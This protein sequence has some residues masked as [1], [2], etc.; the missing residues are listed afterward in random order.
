MV[1]AP[2]MHSFR[3]GLSWSRSPFRNQC[4]AFTPMPGARCG[5]GGSPRLP[6]PRAS[7]EGS[8]A[9]NRHL[10]F[11][12]NLRTRG[13]GKG[14]QRGDGRRRR[15]GRARRRRARSWQMNGGCRGAV[16][17]G[18]RPSG[19]RA[20]GRRPEDTHTFQGLRPPERKRARGT[21]A[22]TTARAGRSRPGRL[23]TETSPK[24]G[25]PRGETVARPE[26]PPT[27]RPTRSSRTPP[28]W[29]GSS[30]RGRRALRGRLAG[31]LAQPGPVTGPEAARVTP[32]RQRPPP[33]PRLLI[34]RHAP[35]VTTGT[36]RF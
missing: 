33:R 22:A 32:P 10:R 18:R 2:W 31:R 8:R 9:H 29:A 13:A 19:A 6:L 24:R 23:V 14:R 36:S 4:T 21:R 28:E 15:P 20:H 11:Q 7:R 17:H 35:H 1:S 5:R 34:G 12:E 26:R 3:A 25:G 27:D 16:V 30:Y